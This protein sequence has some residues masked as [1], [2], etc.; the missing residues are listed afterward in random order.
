MKDHL[1]KVLNK[2]NVEYGEIRLEKTKVRKIMF[3][4]RELDSCIEN[5]DFGGNVRILHKGSWGFTSFNSLD[6]L[7]LKLERA[8]NHARSIGKIRNESFG[9][10]EVPVVDLT[11]PLEVK[12]NPTTVPIKKVLD[13]TGQYN[14]ILLDFDQRLTNAG[15]FYQDRDRQTTFVNTEGTHLRREFVDLEF[16]IRVDVKNDKGTTYGLLRKGSSNDFSVIEGL[17]SEVISTAEKAIKK[18]DAE[19]ISGGTYTVILNPEL[20]GVFIHE[21]FGHLSEGDKVYE[22][23]NLKKVMVFGREFGPKNLDIYDTGLEVGAN[24]YLPFDDEGVATEKTYLMKEGKLCGRLHS[25]ETASKMGEKPTGNA[26]A[27][28]YSFPPIPRMRT[29][30]I[31]KGDVP[32]DEMIKETKNGIYCLGSRGGQTNG[33][34]FTFTALD[35]LMIRNGKMEEVVRDVTLTGNVFETLKNIDMIGNDDK[36]CNGAGGCGKGEQ[37]PLPV[38][39]GSPHIRIQDLTIGGK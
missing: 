28:S 24:G 10:A 12:H 19:V 2:A 35:A 18:A 4:G 13:I 39:F 14:Q 22:D 3:M 29:T 36:V 21:A 38:S 33:E 8:K 7:E 25:R 34:M 20:A 11:I 5:V 23:P 32:L 15:V 37:V 16:G 17:K 6:E 30:M 26:R 9:L 1:H 31:G 27:L